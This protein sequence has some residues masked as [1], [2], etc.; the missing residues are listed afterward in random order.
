MRRMSCSLCFV[1]GLL[2][3]LRAV[4]PNIEVFCAVY[5]YAGK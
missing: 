3:T 2:Y 5:D 1:E 4:P